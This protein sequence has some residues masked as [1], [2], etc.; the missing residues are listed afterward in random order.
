MTTKASLIADAMAD[1]ANSN[2]WGAQ[3]A[4]SGALPVTGKKGEMRQVA[5]DG[6]GNPALYVWDESPGVWKKVGDPDLLGGTPD[7][8]KAAGISMTFPAA[9]TDTIL[10]R[11]LWPSTLSEVAYIHIAPIGATGTGTLKVEKGM[12]QGGNTLLA[13]AGFDLATL[14]GNTVTS[15]SLSAVLADIRGG[16]TDAITVSFVNADVPHIIAFQFKNEV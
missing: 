5:D 3:V 6:D 11:I 13:G 9:G 4:T 14:T 12:S 1:K 8:L 7:L 15:L 2:H 10:E 16:M